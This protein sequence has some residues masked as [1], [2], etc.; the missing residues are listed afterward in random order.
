MRTVQLFWGLVLL[1]VAVVWTLFF[2]IAPEPKHALVGVGQFLGLHAALLMIL[3]LTLVARLPWLD[4]RVGMDRLTSWHRWTGFTLFWVVLLHPLFVMAG[5][6]AVS[7]S[8]TWQ[9]FRNL[10]GMLGSLV[11]MIA[12]V[13]VVVAAAAS[14]RSVRRRLQYETWHAVHVLLYAAVA[15]VLVHQLFEV[16]AFTAAPVATAYWWALWVFALGALLVGRIA[17]PLW[18]NAR[19]RLRVAAVV[20]ESDDVVSVHIS[21]RDLD[22]LPARAGQ[23]FIWRFPG[24]A[25]WWQANPFSLSAAPDG[26]TLRLTAKA[27][28][29]ASAALRHVPVG[30]RVFAE[31]PYGAFTSLRRTRDK[32]LLVAGGVGVTPIRALLE[33]LSGDVVV[34]YRVHSRADAVLLAEL[35]SLAHERGARVHL[36]AGRTGAGS[37]PFAPF[38]P[39]NLATT[40][41]DVAERDIFVCGPPPMTEA[42]IRALRALKVPRSQIHAERFRLAA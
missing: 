5:Y 38:A 21:G 10:A 32:T 41:P 23:F 37:P 28:G 13:V 30:S 25:R 40:V 29:G 31:G 9:Q 34:L 7:H 11:G 39:D 35:E 2:T 4:R 18:R 15:L 33:E 27:V 3:Q 22:R 14:L 24:Y 1:N 20:P 26:R 19:H 6:A 12:L 16:S 17:M 36:L 8:S 42:V